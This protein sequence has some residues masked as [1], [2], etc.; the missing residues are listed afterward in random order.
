MFTCIKKILG[1]YTAF[2]SKRLRYLIKIWE[3]DRFT[4]KTYITLNILWLLIIFQQ[5]MYCFKY[6]N[7]TYQKCLT[8]FKP[9]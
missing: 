5:T 6:K 8:L 1:N 4:L 2:L 9:P 7:K 3:L